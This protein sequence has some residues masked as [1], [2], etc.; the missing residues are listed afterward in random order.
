[1]NT[2]A[3]L[4]IVIKA[5]D[6]ASATLENVGKKAGGVSDL[7]AHSFKDAAI[8]SGVALGG[9]TAEAVL[10]VKAFS[11]HQN[12]L[13]QT[14]AVLKS[15]A[16][17]FQD[18]ST[19]VA[20]HTVTIGI[21]SKQHAELQKQLDSA[22]YSLKIMQDRWDG[23][24]IHTKAAADELEHAK[25]KVTSIEA[26]MNKTTTSMIGGNGMAKAMQITR[27]QVI[28]LSEQMQNLT[29]YSK[30]QVLST[31]NLLLTFTGISKD[32]FP[33]TTTAVLDV[34]TAM[35][36]DLQSAAIQVGKALQDPSTGM[37]QLH[38]I[39][40]DFTKEQIAQAKAM[41]ATGN[42]AGAQALILKELGTEFGGSATA[43]AKTFTG[44]MAQLK[45]V[46]QD[47]QISIGGFIEKALQ[48]I[49]PH[50][51]NVAKALN[52]V[53]TN[54]KPLSEF[55]KTLSQ[56]FGAF[57]TAV[58]NIITFF[59]N[60]RT[61]L[62]ALAG[63][64]GGILVISLAAAT[65]AM[66]SFLAVSLP[67][68][69]IFAALGAGV[70][71]VVTHWKTFKPV[72]DAI[73]PALKALWGTISKFVSDVISAVI[74]FVNTN[75]DT[76]QAFW[77]DVVGVFTF[78][79]GFIQG[80]FKTTWDA[81]KDYLAAVLEIMKGII[82]IAWGIITI[83]ID[84]AMGII[85][86]NWKRAWDGIKQGLSYVWDGIKN[87]IDGG[88]K[89]IIDSIKLALDTVIGLVNGVIDGFNKVAGAASGGKIHIPDIPHFAE[90]G[91]VPAT[92]LAVLHQGEFVMSKA[93]LAG[94]Q[95]VP[96]QIKTTTNNNQPINIYATVNQNID[97]A[98]LGNKIAFALRNSR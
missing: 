83:I 95:Q 39:G 79:L 43:Q 34:A 18:S 11:E 7:L 23:S 42:I 97:M 58:G 13:A 91:F 31:E 37:A 80:F 51:L 74:N 53:L 50:L 93:M 24:K 16:A 61:A 77:T 28:G 72:I 70:A 78:A 21:S 88:V 56:N 69:A 52:D 67:V 1:M 8:V 45:N 19:S 66:L 71:L 75:R 86:G 90:G 44:Q 6:E 12:I 60:N 65:V 5:K 29:T 84:V 38:R 26:A 76:F 57:G 85:T 81:I 87:V 15:T 92:G 32:I 27:E 2:D 62:I 47:I 96:L 40:V 89:Y 10:S 54:G 82:E 64:L 55:T 14:D 94:Q 63:A 20:A 73:T 68:L 9:L 46:F 59:A 41:Q 98:L 33:Q 3:I 35:H 30:D 22:Q 49:L 48:P 17:A 25:E 36:E 4:Q